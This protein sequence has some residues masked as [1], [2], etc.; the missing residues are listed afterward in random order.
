M[1]ASNFFCCRRAKGPELCP[2]IARRQQRTAPF[3]EFRGGR[4]CLDFLS[5]IGWVAIFHLF[6]L[7]K[8]QSVFKLG[9]ELQYLKSKQGRPP[10]ESEKGAVHCC[11]PAM[12][13]YN[14][15]P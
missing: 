13:G 5:K 1:V 11:R 8:V 14:S 9:L 12:R 4:P 15:G 2:R 3:S 10:R 7:V 6:K